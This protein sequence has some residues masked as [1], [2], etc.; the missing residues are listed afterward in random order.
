MKQLNQIPRY[1]VKNPKYGE[2]LAKRTKLQ[3]ESL[4]GKGEAER[5]LMSWEILKIEQEMNDL[6]LQELKQIA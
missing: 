5:L 2:L 3:G 6:V 1:T 4:E